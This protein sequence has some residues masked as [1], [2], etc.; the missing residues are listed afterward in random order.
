MIHPGKHDSFVVHGVDPYD[1]TEN[2]VH[3]VLRRWKLILGSSFPETSLGYQR[4]LETLLQITWSSLY[5]ILLKYLLG[6]LFLTLYLGIPRHRSGTV[7][8]IYSCTE[9]FSSETT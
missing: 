7:E 3:C 4:F 1:E 8:A 6:L 9:K 5:A 2:M